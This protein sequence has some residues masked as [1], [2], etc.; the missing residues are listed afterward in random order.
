MKL[1][2]KLVEKWAGGD[3]FFIGFGGLFRRG[4]LS[5][6][7]PIVVPYAVGK[8]HWSVL[9]ATRSGKTVMLRLLLKQ[10]IRKGYGL[11][12]VDFKPDVDLFS[13][14][15]SE[16]LRTGRAEDFVFFSPFFTSSRQTVEVGELPPTSATWNPL[17]FGSQSEIVSRIL[18]AFRGARQGG[19][20]FWEDVKEDIVDALVGS[21]MGLGKRFNFR[22]LYVTLASDRAREWVIE[23]TQNAESRERLRTLHEYI[24]TNPQKAQVLI[25]GT[26]VALGR[27][28]FG[29]YSPYLN[30]YSPSFFLA[31]AVREGRIVYV[32]LSYQK[33]SQLATAVAKML[34][35]ELNSVVG[36]IL[37]REGKLRRKFFVV[38]DEFANCV[39][40]GIEDLFN[41]SAGAGITMVVA[42][43]SMSDVVHR[44]GESMLK[45][46]MDNTHVKVFL[47]QT[48]ADA[49]KFVE[50][51]SPL[52]WQEDRRVWEFSVTN[53]LVPFE[54][55]RSETLQPEIRKEY[56]TNLKPLEFYAK[57]GDRWYR[58][59]VPILVEKKPVKDVS[60]FYEPPSLSEGG[61]DLF[62]RFGDV[63]KK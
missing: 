56:I 14:A 17:I 29:D 2:A 20:Q 15:F 59:K 50:D 38:I 10:A 7:S 27:F 8:A 13:I 16:A 23:N 11:L 32:A 39:F 63:E 36:D 33:S 61:L 45:I 4:G 62:G 37:L 1:D 47:M 3:D 22:D 46:Y 30:S 41:K 6:L 5:S 54:L 31:D 58:G 35:S 26:L 43:Q 52:T 19:E 24:T 44:A 51:M 21:L 9:G 28:A 12:L 18:N 34:I 48:G 60:L 42:H 49:G 55:N 57:I 25:R 53:L 40:P